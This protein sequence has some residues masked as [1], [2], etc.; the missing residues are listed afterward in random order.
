M[1]NERRESDED[2]YTQYKILERS[3]LASEDRYAQAGMRAD[4]ARWERGR[5]PIALA[6]DRD[7]SFLDVGCANGIL[8]ESLHRWA[9]E[10]GC[11]IEPYGLD[12]SGPLADLARSRLS[13]WADRIFVGNIINWHP[14][15]RFDYVRTELVYVPPQRRRDLVTRLLNEIVTPGGRAIIAS[16]GSS[17]RPQPEFQV[18]PIGDILR[19]LGFSVAGEREGADDNGVI[20]V[21]VAWIDAP[22]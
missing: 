19:D 11:R 15:F 2:Y 16:Y 8:M 21:K 12:I 4:A 6:F 20:I 17:R 18:E 13:E 22:G 3:Y 10:D 5:R 9:A 1:G 7:G 14:P